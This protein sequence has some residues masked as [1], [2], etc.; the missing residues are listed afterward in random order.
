[1]HI[2]HVD[3]ANQRCTLLNE[4]IL[5]T[6]ISPSKQKHGLRRKENARVQFF[7]NEHTHIHKYTNAVNASDIGTYVHA[8][9]LHVAEEINMH[10]STEKC[11]A[12]KVN[13]NKKHGCCYFSN[14]FF[15]D[16]SPFPSFSVCVSLSVPP[17][18]R[19]PA[20]GLCRNN[21]VIFLF[22]IFA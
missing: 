10:E 8:R 5:K 1:M 18:L 12:Q 6:N 22:R 11:E 3:V 17:K 19:T 7:Q 2:T 16:L 15:T 21:V 9:A 20:F 4:C 13:N 14:S